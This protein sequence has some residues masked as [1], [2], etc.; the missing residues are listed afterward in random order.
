MLL[1][2]WST[3]SE[4][5]VRELEIAEDET[6]VVNI[7]RQLIVPP[8]EDDNIWQLSLTLHF[9]ATRHARRM[10]NGN[11]WCKRPDEL[12]GFEEFVRN[13]TAYKL[14]AHTPTEKVSLN[15]GFVG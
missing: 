13:S 9:A 2:Q 4:Q 10:K 8:G 11:R 12:I 5:D 14:I 7:T 1:F 3:Y 6:F 15:F